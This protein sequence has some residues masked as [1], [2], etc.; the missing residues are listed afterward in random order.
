[1]LWISIVAAFILALLL[2]AYRERHFRRSLFAALVEQG[3][4][5]ALNPLAYTPAKRLRAIQQ[6]LARKG[7]IGRRRAN[8]ARVRRRILRELSR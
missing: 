5:E 1:M 3:R 2:A 6:R 7:G 4:R 8:S